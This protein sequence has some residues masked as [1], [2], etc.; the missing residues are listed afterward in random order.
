MFIK[1]KCFTRFITSHSGEM[2]VYVSGLGGFRT[3][4]AQRTLVAV[5]VHLRGH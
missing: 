2:T 4:L 1:W 3:N 5:D